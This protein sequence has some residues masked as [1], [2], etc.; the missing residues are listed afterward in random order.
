VGVQVISIY[1]HGEKPRPIPSNHLVNDLVGYGSDRGR[2][3]GV[4]RMEA[5]REME[6]FCLGCRLIGA[7]FAVP[8]L[9]GMRDLTGKTSAGVSIFGYRR[10]SGSNE[11]A[12]RQAHPLPW[13]LTPALCG[14]HV[15]QQGAG[16]G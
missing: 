14:D 5:E 1:M 12:A 13:A 8:S 7:R 4:V 2:S 6:E 16:S 10:N 9:H 3:D 15:S 11:M